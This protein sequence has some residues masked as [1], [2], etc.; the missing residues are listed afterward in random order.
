MTRPIE[1]GQTQVLYRYLPGALFDHDTFGLCKVESV[2]VEGVE[3]DQLNDSALFDTL[4][5]SL[6]QWTRA[7][8]RSS[9]PEVRDVADRR[10]FRVGI[11]KQ[12]HFTP[13]PRIVQCTNPKCG[14]VS[15][16]NN[17]KDGRSQCPRCNS[18]MRQLR[19]VEAHNCGRMQ[20]MKLPEAC[21]N[22]K[23]RTP[24]LFDPGR[25]SLARWVCTNCGHE[26]RKLRMSPCG[27]AYAA[28]VGNDRKH[29]KFLRV[30]PA[31]EPGL[32]IP[33]VT[34]FVNFKKRDEERLTQMN[35]AEA[36]MLARTWGVLEDKVLDVARQR[37]QGRVNSGNDD[38]LRRV[39]EKLRKID[40]NAPE[41]LDF[42]ARQAN[43]PGEAEI[44]KVHDLLGTGFPMRAIP[45]RKLIE[46][47]ALRDNMQ[48]TS[49]KKVAQR[50]RERGETGRADSFTSESNKIMAE[51]GLASVEAI[52]DF[53]I[54]QVAFGF[55]RVTRDPNRSIINPFHS[56]D[57]RYP[58]Y[59]LPTETEGLWFQL[60]PV[61]V[62]GW[63]SANGFVEGA[64]PTEQAEAWAWL[65]RLALH[66]GFQRS[67][68]LS[69]AASAVQVLVHTISHIMLQRIEWSGFASSSVGEYLLPDTLSFVLYANRFTESKIGGLLTLFEQRLPLWL[70]EAVQNGRDC[71]YDP[72]CGREGG[73][74]AGCLHREHNCSHFNH[75]LSRAV[76][77][78]GNLPSDSGQGG[79]RIKQG[80][81]H[82]WTPAI[83]K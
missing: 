64:A 69:V 13:Y 25:T 68:E 72:I 4:Q 8:F 10:R 5:E 71:V 79:K 11:P 41:V 61:A 83:T 51:L 59:V 78:G 55:T 46:H 56:D 74:C 40:S 50:L 47:T 15:Q 81:W 18:R 43:P 1:R 57:G 33:Q 76:L 58:I 82:A 31:T 62:A 23:K 77:Y 80:F 66:Q 44:K 2:D 70:H 53:P 28:S 9:Y 30:Y 35:D 27:C 45:P 67:T 26:I 24:R 7:E 22:C 63:L 20:E 73:S 19:Y 52:E 16:Y 12:V 42:D 60:D 75:H 48:I 34:A 49:V 17:V 39:I 36:L 65:H 3:D 21:P 14:F 6:S 54:A 38:V 29:E 37:E 32:F